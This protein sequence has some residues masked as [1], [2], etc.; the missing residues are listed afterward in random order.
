[1]MFER[2]WL[3]AILAAVRPGSNATPSFP[4]GALAPASDA[5]LHI[6]EFRD[7]SCDATHRPRM[8]SI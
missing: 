3:A 6:G 1:V 2:D 8:T 5:Q 4:D 7:S